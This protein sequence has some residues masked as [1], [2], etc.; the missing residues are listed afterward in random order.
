MTTNTCM[1]VYELS[2]YSCTL[3]INENLMVIS[4][5]ITRSHGEVRHTAKLHDLNRVNIVLSFHPEQALFK[6]FCC[7]WIGNLFLL[8][9][10]IFVVATFIFIGMSDYDGQNLFVWL[11]FR[12]VGSTLSRLSRSS[13]SWALRESLFATSWTCCSIL[14]IDSAECCCSG[15]EFAWL[16]LGWILSLL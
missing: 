14:T 9:A 3:F 10:I 5:L 1:K 12:V 4:K 16:L 7:L 2:L 15:S 8:W 6:T 13:R 11:L